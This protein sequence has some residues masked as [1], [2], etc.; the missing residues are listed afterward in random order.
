VTIEYR[1]PDI[2]ISVSFTKDMTASGWGRS[3]GCT[4][5]KERIT[6]F[7]AKEVEFVVVSLTA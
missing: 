2:I 1:K 4:R 6:A 5:V 3:R 7:S